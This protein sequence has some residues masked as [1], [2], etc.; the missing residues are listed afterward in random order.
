[1]EKRP[2]LLSRIWSKVTS[3]DTWAWLFSLLPKQLREWLRD[4]VWR[5]IVTLAP[6]TVALLIGIVEGI[7]IFW[8]LVGT[9]GTLAFAF[10]ISLQIQSAVERFK[11]QRRA[12]KVRAISGPT[13]G[14]RF[15]PAGGPDLGTPAV[16][17]ARLAV[18]PLRFLRNCSATITHVKGLNIVKGKVKGDDKT[19][20]TWHDLAGG[21]PCE[22]GWQSNGR[23]RDLVPGVARNLDVAVLDQADQTKFA[24]VA[25]DG[26][27][28]ELPPGWYKVEVNLASESDDP[29]VQV[30]EMAIAFGPREGMP[31]P[32]QA[33]L[34]KDEYE[35]SLGSKD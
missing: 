5:P 15:I 9:F 33:L 12:F 35:H 23:T 6:P 19:I 7:P 34:W 27:R 3:A 30:V 31:P 8:L 29:A 10:W 28:V 17:Y 21:F 2:N 22:I 26:R 16:V 11:A 32:L 13:G 4:N 24:F 18:E 25:V 1:M 20:R 14:T